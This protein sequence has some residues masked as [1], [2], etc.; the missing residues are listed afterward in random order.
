ML[1]LCFAQKKILVL[2]VRTHVHKVYCTE[3]F[4]KF[5]PHLGLIGIIWIAGMEE[6]H[7]FLAESQ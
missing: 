6:K 2:G 1:A 5:A 3:T 4:G 7:K